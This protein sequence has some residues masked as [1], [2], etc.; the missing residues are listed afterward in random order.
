V[1]AFGD[2]NGDGLI[3]PG[4]VQIEVGDSPSAGSPFPTYEAALRTGAA[5]GRRLR[6]SAA[7]DRRSGQKLFNA[8]GRARCSVIPRCEEQHDPATSLDVQA[9]AVAG[10]LGAIGH[11][12]EDASYTKLREVSVSLELPRTWTGATAA[13]LTLF[14]RN[15]YTWTSYRGLDPELIA[16]DRNGIAAVDMSRQPPLRTFTARLDLSW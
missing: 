16:D 13:K 8:T 14:G 7:V 5:F 12:I 11:W 4:E 6:V 15:L 10:S 3:G 9:G 2:A 1:Y